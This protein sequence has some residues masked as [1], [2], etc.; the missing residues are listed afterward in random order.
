MR[1]AL[2]PTAATAKSRCENQAPYPARRSSASLFDNYWRDCAL[3]NTCY[4]ASDTAF[5]AAE[6]DSESTFTKVAESGQSIM[7]IWGM[8]ALRRADP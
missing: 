6:D 2:S 4:P 5:F 1:V 3:R 7:R 8:A